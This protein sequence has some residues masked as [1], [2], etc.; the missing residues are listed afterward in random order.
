MSAARK[1]GNHVAAHESETSSV[2]LAAV[3]SDV[4]FMRIARCRY[5]PVTSDDVLWPTTDVVLPC[6]SGSMSR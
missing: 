3:Q 6:E 5:E 2:R 4:L 1:E